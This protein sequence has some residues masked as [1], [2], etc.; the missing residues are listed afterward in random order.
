ME[1][2]WCLVIALSLGF[3]PSD[4]KTTKIEGIEVSKVSK[5]VKSEDS[6]SYGNFT[7]KV[8]FVALPT[9]LDGIWKE[10]SVTS[11]SAPMNFVALYPNRC[12]DAVDAEWN[13]SPS[14]PVTYDSGM[15]CF[16]G[17]NTAVRIQFISGGTYTISARVKNKNGVWTNWAYTTVTRL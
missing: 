16:P 10:A 11:I 2:L 5:H 1:G 14:A 7:N 8:G 3:A 17:N 15:E 13:V 12:D 6:F 4:E 9:I